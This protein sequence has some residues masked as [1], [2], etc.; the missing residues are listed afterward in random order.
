MGSTNT[1]STSAGK[2]WRWFS[3]AVLVHLLFL[4]AV[5]RANSWSLDPLVAIHDG[6]YYVTHLDDLLLQSVPEWW[7]NVP[8]RAIRVGFVLLA[9]P[10][11]FFGSV[12]ALVIANLVGVGAGAVA[13][14]AVARRH[15][16][17]E[18]IAWAVW[19]LNPGALVASA[20]ILPD[21]IAWAA[22]LMALLAI[23]DR[24]WILATALCIF[25][26]LTKEASL[27]AL[28]LAALMKL[29]TGSPKALIPVGLAG[30]A[31]VGLLAILIA[32]FGAPSHT[33]FLSWPLVGWVEAVPEWLSFR[34]FS[35][36][37]GIFVFASGLLVIVRW[38]RSKSFYLAAAAG[39]ALLMVFLSAL[40]VAPLAATA[41]IGGLFWPLLAATYSKAERMGSGGKEEESALLP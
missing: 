7:D 13:I 10:F 39:Q 23:D 29:R 27:A 1:T 37:V 8:Y 28:G 30:A 19:V 11:K 32:S 40:V 38:W 41:R 26:A 16:A 12:P 4:T 31:H 34:P 25:A 17:S 9:L 18:N 35:G 6:I 20:L 3:I 22:I 21:T 36:V 14:R 5:A 24:K 2:S 33:G 15:G